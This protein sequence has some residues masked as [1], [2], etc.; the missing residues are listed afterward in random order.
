M[1]RDVMILMGWAPKIETLLGPKMAKRE[2][3]AIWA[4]KS[5]DFQ[6]T[7]F[8]M[9][10]VMYLPQSKSLSPRAINIFCHFRAKKS[11]FSVFRA[12]PFQWP[13]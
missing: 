10:R 6:G 13:L 5:L 8:P 1:A 3:S 2:A 4:R 9:G 11:R 12:H 7:P